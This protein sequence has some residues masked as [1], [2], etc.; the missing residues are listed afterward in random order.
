MNEII[1]S[2]VFLDTYSSKD[3][4]IK[5]LPSFFAYAKC[6]HSL[7]RNDPGCSKYRAIYGEK[8]IRLRRFK[9]PRTGERR[10]TVEVEI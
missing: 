5:P 10:K 2:P 1:I 4:N 3:T 6:T 8:F 7:R 9:D